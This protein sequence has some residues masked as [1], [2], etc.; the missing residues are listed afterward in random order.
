MNLGSSRLI[1]M[2]LRIQ[3]MTIYKMCPSWVLRVTRLNIRIF[4]VRNA[5]RRVDMSGRMSIL[6]PSMYGRRSTLPG[7]RGLVPQ[8]M[9]FLTRVTELLATLSLVRPTP[10][11]IPPFENQV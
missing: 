2:A 6:M 10:C 8:K 7:P 11:H 3:T 1:Q 5:A 9:G 4:P